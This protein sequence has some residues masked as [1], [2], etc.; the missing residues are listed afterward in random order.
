M[1]GLVLRILKF[2][3]NFFINLS[4]NPLKRRL[5]FLQDLEIHILKIASN[6]GN[7][8]DRRLSKE[9]IKTLYEKGH[10]EFREVFTDKE[11]NEIWNVLA[12]ARMYYWA[13]WYQEYNNDE[14]KL[15][16][17]DRQFNIE[18]KKFRTNSNEAYIKRLFSTKK[19]SEVLTEVE[20]RHINDT[21]IA[22]LVP[23]EFMISQLKTKLG[24]VK[25]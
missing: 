24:I 15:L 4:T 13:V 12:S 1:T 9:F 20:I 2:L 18:N 10:E 17:A 23:L 14:M 19:K 5:A 7:E 11:L 3:K 21:L 25:T 22:D 8:N 16:I 6:L